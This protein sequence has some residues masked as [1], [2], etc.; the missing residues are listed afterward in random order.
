[1]SHPLGEE[2]EDYKF[3]CFDGEPRILFVATDRST[4]CRFD[5]FDMDFHHLDIQNLH[6]NADKLIAKPDNF[7]LLKETASKLSKGM[8][9]VRVDLYSINNKVY[10]GE[11]TFFHGGGFCLFTPFEW[12]KRLGD[13]IQLN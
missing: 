8:K 10:F 1:M 13:W 5:F 12:E 4:D 11:Y 3:F 7:E 2:V 6:P 9:F